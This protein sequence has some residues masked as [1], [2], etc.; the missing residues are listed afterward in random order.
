M[1]QICREALG[2]FSKIGPASQAKHPQLRG[3]CS[4]ILSDLKRDATLKNENQA[5]QLFIN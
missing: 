5:I 2:S 1:Q 4:N 3:G